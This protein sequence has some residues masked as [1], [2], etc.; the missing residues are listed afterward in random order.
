MIA[1]TPEHYDHILIKT[2]C[3]GI[4]STKESNVDSMAF[5]IQEFANNILHINTETYLETRSSY[6]RY[7][8]KPNYSLNYNNIINGINTN[9]IIV[10]NSTLEPLIKRPEGSGSSILDF[11]RYTD[12]YTSVWIDK[13]KDQF[14][15]QN[16]QEIT[17]IDAFLKQTT[18]V[19]PLKRIVLI[20]TLYPVSNFNFYNA[21]LRRP[22]IVP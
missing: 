4:I 5:D 11:S 22:E 8:K 21:V 10:M 20:P 18:D 13:D 2:N 12:F 9:N 6:R 1:L 16:N 17:T 3:C 14:V 19:R 7:N 15:D